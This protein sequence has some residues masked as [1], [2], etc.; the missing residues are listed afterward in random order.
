LAQ[1]N[2]S[3]S[4][5]RNRLLAALPRATYE[6]LLPSLEAV[7]LEHR[8]P[9]AAPDEPM[10]YVY[11]PRGAVVSVLAPMDDGGSVEAATIG[12]EGMIGLPVF[13]ADGVSPD[14]VICQIGGDAARLSATAFRQAIADSHELTALLRWYTLA[15]MGQMARTAGCNRAHPVEERCARWL[16]LTH[17]RVGGDE[18]FLTQ[19]FLAAMLGTRR[20]SVSLIAGQLQQ[21]GLI[22]YRRGHMTIL[23]REGLEAAACEDYQLTRDLY[24]RLYLGHQ[25]AARRDAPPPR[26]TI[27]GTLA[28]PIR[29]RFRT[30][31]GP[32]GSRRA[33]TSPR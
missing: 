17:D 20:P 31:P 10:D 14:E 6:A 12:L 2:S 3:A 8:F 16:L 33:T 9:L 24:E 32:P 28:R 29:R 26:A 5:E 21:A 11:F 27:I 4:L 1:L 22:R 25:A 30:E 15:L 13:L 23:D 7:R 19:E 18:F